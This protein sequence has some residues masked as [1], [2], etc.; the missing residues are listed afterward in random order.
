M[1]GGVLIEE[2]SDGDMETRE[3]GLGRELMAN[4]KHLGLGFRPIHCH[5][6]GG[7]ALRS[8][9]AVVVGTRAPSMQG[10]AWSRVPRRTLARQGPRTLEDLRR[11]KRGRDG[12]EALPVVGS[13]R[14]KSRGIT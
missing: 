6:V 12:R 11:E 10:L 5:G 7:N 2:L 13:G 9:A 3:V 4:V 8:H 14:S 1:D